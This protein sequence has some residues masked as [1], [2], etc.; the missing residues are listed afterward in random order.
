MGSV[1]IE[2]RPAMKTTIESTA[3]KIGRSMKKRDS[4]M[5]LTLR[6]CGGR[7]IPRVG[8]VRDHGRHGR[9]DLD[10]RPDPH[11]TVDDDLVARLDAGSHDSE[12]IRERADLDRAI[13][14]TVALAEQEDELPVLVRA[15]GSVTHQQ[16]R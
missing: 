3:A 8:R 7:R 1:T 11:E 4:R 15:D 10:A 5:G 6:R 14:Q 16:R 9:R 2:I 13:H 12:A